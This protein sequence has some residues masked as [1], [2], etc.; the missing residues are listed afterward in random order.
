MKSS[1]VG[2]Y[3][4]QNAPRWKLF[5]TGR[6][7]L[8]PLS[9]D[10]DGVLL[11]TFPQTSYSRQIILWLY[12]ADMQPPQHR[13]THSINSRSN[14]SRQNELANI[15]TFRVFNYT[16]VIFVHPPTYTWDFIPLDTFKL[17]SMKLFIQPGQYPTQWSFDLWPKE[18]KHCYS[19]MEFMDFKW[20]W[21]HFY[22]ITRGI[23]FL[24]QLPFAIE[25]I[26]LLLLAPG[27]S[28]ATPNP[29]SSTT[30]RM[31]RRRSPATFTLA[32]INSVACTP[33][34][35]VLWWT[36]I[37][38]RKPLSTPAHDTAL[39]CIGTGCLL[40]MYYLSPM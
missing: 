1:V 37:S 11:L 16:Q 12:P 9:P 31:W 40:F 39:N 36:G 29:V 6:L 35:V 5:H 21:S 7:R 25:T 14:T 15:H 18:N 28:P 10:D 27:T 19:P 3:Y 20:T 32:A 22:T 33:L 26:P 38:Y 13:H 23:S 30:N 4:S 24:K 34:V 8:P 2:L 17:H